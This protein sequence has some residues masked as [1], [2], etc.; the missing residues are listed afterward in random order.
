[1]Y[2]SVEAKLFRE[3]PEVS[4]LS[5]FS[6]RATEVAGSEA[7]YALFLSV[8]SSIQPSLKVEVGDPVNE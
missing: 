3:R 5:R 7:S 1:M 8:V 2:F 4:L 6:G